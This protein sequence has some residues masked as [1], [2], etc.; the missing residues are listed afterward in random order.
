MGLQNS[1][2]RPDINL[3]LQ[4]LGMWTSRADAAM[5]TTEV[6]WDSLLRGT[7]PEQYVIANYKDLVNFYHSKKFKIWVYIDPQNGLDRSTD[8]V[9]LV[10]AGKSI[11]QADM[12]QLYRRFVI[13]MDSI[14]K[15]DHIG[16]ALETNLIRAAS[17]SAIYQ[18][19][20]QAANNAAMDLRLVDKNVKLSVSVQVDYAWGSLGTN[21]YRGI[22]QDFIDFPFI[23]E[24]GLSSY[25]Y[26]TD[27]SV[28]N[29][30]INYYSR[31]IEGKS[32]PVF[33]SEGGWTSQSITGFSGNIITSNPQIQR[34]Y[35]SLQSKLL[36]EAK[37]IAWFQ[38]TFSDID[39]SG[40]PS[41]YPPNLKYFTYL[42]LVDIQL[43]PKPAQEAWDSIF[44]LPLKPGN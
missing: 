22:S 31:L 40:W 24:L 14:L 44:K 29:I 13:V 9:A 34:D 21:S 39:L 3:I 11:A 41:S 18:G 26:L 28:K 6:P 42:G 33:V 25:P 2:P 7:T 15:P 17:S 38:L 19:V 37:A 16:L 30:P 5:I 10:A 27:V 23:E 35:I 1:A 8:A 32:L 20:R 43:K 36:G 4:A 12:Q